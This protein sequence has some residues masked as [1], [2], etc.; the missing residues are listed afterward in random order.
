MELNGALLVT[1]VKSVALH[2]GQQ[3]DQRETGTID[4]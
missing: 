4:L 3:D 1:T 2:E